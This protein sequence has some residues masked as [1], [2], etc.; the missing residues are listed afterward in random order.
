MQLFSPTGFVFKKIKPDLDIY[1][2]KHISESLTSASQRR[3]VLQ[4]CEQK[5]KK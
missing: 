2:Y 4:V 1:Y 5:C 3:V